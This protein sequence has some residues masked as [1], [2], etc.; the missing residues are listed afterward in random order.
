MT[1]NASNQKSN[2]DNNN[3]PTLLKAIELVLAKPAVIM[4]E[5]QTLHN[6]LKEKYSGDK[7]DDE[8]ADLVA[9]KIISNYSYYAAFV[10]G[11][12][13]LTG[14]VPR[15]GTII[16]TFGGATADAGFQ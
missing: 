14:I 5:A 7:T 4:K 1:E 10:G 15:L 13:A 6:H 3:K 2:N 9:E 12:T 11:V 16:A 8:I